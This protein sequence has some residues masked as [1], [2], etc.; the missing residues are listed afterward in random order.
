MCLCDPQ[1]RTPFCNNCVN[2]FN[3]MQVSKEKVKELQPHQ[4]RVVTERDELNDKLTKLTAFIRRDDFDKVVPVLAERARLINQSNAMRQYLM[5]LNE[6]IKHFYDSDKD[7]LIDSL[8][9]YGFT[10]E[11]GHKLEDC[12]DFINLTGLIK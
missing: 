2:K 5:I 6:R 10:D 7:A 8:K 9:E 3:E 1:K 4:Q 11:H 12:K